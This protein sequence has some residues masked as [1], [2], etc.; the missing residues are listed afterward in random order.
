MK[1]IKKEKEKYVSPSRSRLHIFS[2]ECQYGWVL[3]L[4]AVVEVVGWQ[5]SV[6]ICSDRSHVCR[7]NRVTVVVAYSTQAISD[8]QLMFESASRDAS[9]FFYFLVLFSLFPQ[10]SQWFASLSLAFVVN[11][12]QFPHRLQDTSLGNGSYFLQS[13]SQ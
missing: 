1:L 7:R 10:C 5:G 3:R 8:F 9:S 12:T 13:C 6:I 2:L 4:F 11:H